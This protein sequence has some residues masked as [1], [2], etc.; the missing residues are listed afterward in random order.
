V[1]ASSA[2]TAEQRGY[3]AYYL[4]TLAWFAGDYDVARVQYREAKEHADGQ[5]SALASEMLHSHWGE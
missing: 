4:A 2:A 3:A 5:T 1:H